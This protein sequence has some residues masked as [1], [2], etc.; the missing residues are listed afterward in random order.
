MDASRAA[1]VLVCPC[2]Q[3]SPL[4]LTR[5]AR[6]QWGLA[7]L[8]PLPEHREA[9]NLIARALMTGQVYRDRT[10]RRPVDRAPDAP[11]A[12]M[13]EAYQASY[14]VA[15]QACTALSQ[16]LVADSRRLAERAL[17][18]HA[19]Y[20][21]HARTVARRRTADVKTGRWHNGECFWVE[22]AVPDPAQPDAG[23]VR[24]RFTF[25]FLAVWGTALTLPEGRERR[26]DEAEIQQ[27]SHT[28][29]L[30]N[31]PDI[32]RASGLPVGPDGWRQL[33]DLL[34]RF[35]SGKPGQAP[36]PLE[37]VWY[38]ESG[39]LTLRRHI[40]QRYPRAVLALEA[41][42]R[43]LTPVQPASRDQDLAFELDDEP[44]WVADALSPPDLDDEILE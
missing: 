39:K 19:A 20:Q 31:G 36:D 37:L 17:A 27:G 44:E 30:L 3:R 29:A 11:S 34:T 8:R 25:P 38:S 12:Q 16:G 28:L 21:A 1:Q 41:L 40:R 18:L 2:E 10:A 14:S 6:G 7:E 24:R 13:V 43:V 42:R 35:E 9:H 15:V 32:E 22:L 26:G 4:T 5:S 33:L 23:P